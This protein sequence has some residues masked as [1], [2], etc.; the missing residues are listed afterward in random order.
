M[1]KTKKERAM[2]YGL[3]WEREKNLNV[4]HWTGFDMPLH[5]QKMEK[6]SNKNR[7]GMKS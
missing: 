1:Q 2:K 5:R 7:N 3:N 4:S 6:T